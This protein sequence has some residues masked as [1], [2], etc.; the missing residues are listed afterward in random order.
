MVSIKFIIKVLEDV[1]T[2]MQTEQFWSQL[3]QFIDIFFAAKYLITKLN[4][5]S[6]ISSIN[7]E[8]NSFNI[9]VICNMKYICCL[10]E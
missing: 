10:F 7:Y 5:Y 4:L 8:Y 3:N 9:L 1:K 6:T 2:T